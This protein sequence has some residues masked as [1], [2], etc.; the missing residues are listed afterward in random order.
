MSSCFIE[1][2]SELEREGGVGRTNVR[3]DEVR[4]ITVP[5]RLRMDLFMMDEGAGE[6]GVEF[7]IAKKRTVYKSRMSGG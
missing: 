1:P 6:L 4:R 5:M 2:D 7:G 3:T